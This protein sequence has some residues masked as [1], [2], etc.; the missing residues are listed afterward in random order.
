M[1]ATV[2]GQKKFDFPDSYEMK[3]KPEAEAD[4]DLCV[5]IPADSEDGSVNPFRCLPGYTQ[6]E[7][8]GCDKCTLE[9]PE[10]Q[11]LN[12]LDCECVAQKAECPE[13]TVCDTWGW[14]LDEEC[15]C[16]DK[17]SYVPECRN[18]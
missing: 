18:Q 9:C 17:T 2:L 11:R 3:C 4:T 8:C 13:E 10:G 6:N 5:C 14:K 15:N 16:V 12:K 7:S 1:A